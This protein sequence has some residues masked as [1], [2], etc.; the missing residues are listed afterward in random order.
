M[1]TPIYIIAEFNSLGIH[2]FFYF[3]NNYFLIKDITT[4]VTSD[5]E[6]TIMSTSATSISTFNSKFK[7]FFLSFLY[8]IPASSTSTII[9]TNDQ[10]PTNIST[11]IYI[12]TGCVSSIYL[13]ICFLFI[14]LLFRS[15]Y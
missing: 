10:I 6:E 3:L 14:L 11:P 9:T 1:S 2:L 13:I 12:I 8:F 15:F 7:V 5:P 4:E